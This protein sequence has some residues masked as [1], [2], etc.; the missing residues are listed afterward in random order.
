MGRGLVLIWAVAQ[1]VC[2]LVP[3]YIC[4]G[5]LEWMVMEDGLPWTPQ[6]ASGHIPPAMK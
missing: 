1:T 5:K 6:K 4:D 3:P 2:V